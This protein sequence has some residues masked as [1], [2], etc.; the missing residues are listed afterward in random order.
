VPDPIARASLAQLRTFLRSFVLDPGLPFA[1]ILSARS[2][3]EII[4]QEAGK[5]RD[6]IFTPVV[7]LCTF[8]TQIFSDD[9]S[10]QAAVLR[11]LAGRTAEG[12]P[13]CST[14]TGGYCKARQRLPETLLPRLTRQTGDELQRQAPAAW[15]FQ[16]RPVKIVDGS[17]VSMP[18]TPEN[19]RDYPQPGSQRPGCGFPV[20]RIVVVLS[21]ATGAV[22]EAALGRSKGKQ[23]GE[24]AL[25]RGL[26]ES[27]EPGNIVLADRY[28]C[29][30]FE[31]ATLAARGV[32]V[33]MRLHQRRR[34]DFRR[35]RRLGREDH[36]VEW[37]KPARPSWMDEATCAALPEVLTVREVRV[38]VTRPGFRTKSLVV[39]TTLLDA[40]RVTREDLAGLYRARWHA[41]LDLRSIKQTMQM[42]VLRCQTPE[43]VR[44]EIWGHLLVYNLIRAVMAQAAQRH[45]VL[46]RQISFQGT[47]QTLK[48]F[49]S[50]LRAASPALVGVLVETVLAAIASQRVGD[51][52]DRV[53]PRVR[54]RRP[55][56]YPLMREPRRKA[57]KRLRRA[58]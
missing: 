46:P 58:A 38:R 15:L 29:S 7:T 2:L 1:Q 53:E 50:I 33:V 55:K 41:E 16:G 31:I 3:L 25:F 40:Q 22:L 57:Q 39:V 17:G 23:T 51:R 10:C 32:D 6:S 14:N 13:P 27:L 54:K 37:H 30:Y 24:T 4:T 36:L 35:G 52:P 9:Q 8:L 12:L 26:H 43:M 21:L 18:D 5:T 47:R 49:G 45:G 42:D 44:K 48:A 28:Y 56:Q 34:V 19:Q 20:A 11:L